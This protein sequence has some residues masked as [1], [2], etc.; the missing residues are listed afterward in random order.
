MPDSS[1]ER[2]PVELLAEDFM[3]RKRRGE[4]PTLSEYTAQHPDLA[5]DI[6]EL[7]PALLMMED[8]GDSSLA[9]T[10]PHQIGAGAAPERIG[11][12]RILREVGRGGM[13]VVYEA[14]QESLG[15]RVA[16]KVLP[17][18]VLNDS[19]QVRR[20]ERE[21]RA[22]AK[23]HH[24]NIVPVFGVGSDQ[25][26]HYY[27]M[28]FIQG[29]GLDEVLEELKRF[30]QSRERQRPVNGSPP[31]ANAPGSENAPRSPVSEIAQSLAT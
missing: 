30:R 15:R 9:A 2:N 8:L 17:P 29:L 3:A 4:K 19:Q 11:D 24:T 20:F 27:V 26:M 6:R 1:D 18:H 14:E 31:V 5:D 13:G 10:G 22:A 21:A 12:Y 23:L 25:G 16:L 28:Q 7:F